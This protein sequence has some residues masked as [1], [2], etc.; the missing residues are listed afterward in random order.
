MRG[1]QGSWPAKAVGVL[2]IARPAVICRPRSSTRP[3]EM[4]KMRFVPE[5][6]RITAPHS[7]ASSVTSRP[8]KSWVVSLYSPEAREMAGRAGSA[9][10]A[11]S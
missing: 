6:R 4:K 9:N 5:P 8:I 10:A 3:D 2:T 11:I 1:G 7:S